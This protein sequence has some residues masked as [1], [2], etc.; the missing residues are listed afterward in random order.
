MT[1]AL[2]VGNGDERAD[3]RGIAPGA[4]LVFVNGFGTGAGAL[5][6]MTEQLAYIQ[7]GKSPQLPRPETIA[8]L[9][10]IAGTVWYRAIRS[11]R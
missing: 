5:G 11:D 2:A 1:S 9:G 7:I 6:A 4:D 3:A 8:E 10:R